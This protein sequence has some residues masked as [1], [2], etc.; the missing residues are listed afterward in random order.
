MTYG[1]D[2]PRPCRGWNCFIPDQRWFAPPANIQ[3]PSGIGFCGDETVTALLA[4]GGAAA[5]RSTSMAPRR[6]NLAKLFIH[7]RNQQ[8]LKKMKKSLSSVSRFDKRDELHT[9]KN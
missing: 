1:F 6:F 3:H 8:F 5:T 2:L 7:L 4:F 9:E